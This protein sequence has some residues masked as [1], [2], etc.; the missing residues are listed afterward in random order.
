MPLILIAI[1]M[2]FLCSCGDTIVEGN[3]YTQ[4]NISGNISVIVLDAVTI[5]SVKNANVMLLGKDN[6]PMETNSNSTITYENLPVGN[7]YTFHIEAPGYASVLCKASVS[8][9][10]MAGS[11]ETVV[12]DDAVL[13]VYLPK[14]GA[15]LQGS[16]AYTDLQANTISIPAAG[17]GEAKLRLKLNIINEC[18]LINPYREASTGLNGTYFFDSLPELAHYELT[19]LESRIDNMVYRQFI[20]ESYGVLGLSGDIAKAP[21]GI[22]AEAVSLEKFR[23]LNAPDTVS[24]DGKISLLFSK[25]INKARTN[26]SA[27]Y[28][29]G[30]NYAVEAKWNGERTLEVSPIGG[31]WNV[32]DLITISNSSYLYATDGTY[33]NYG[34]L[35]AVRVTNGALGTVPKFWLEN[36]G[37]GTALNAK[38]DSL[39]LDTFNLQGQGLGFRWNK[40]NNA[41]S[42][43]IYAKCTGEINYTPLSVS[44]QS[45]TSAICSYS[46]AFYCFEKDRHSSFFIQA[47]N[48]RESTN[49][50]F[51]SVTGYVKETEQ[52]E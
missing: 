11:K 8:P 20:V 31:I 35:A 3:A 24:P 44:L 45:D 27:F 34:T 22:Y 33:L 29:T 9:D 1:F 48:P 7:N 38:G 21:L 40:A 49:S 47:K 46:S 43:V 28:I 50:D 23:L 12:V 19:A 2:L 17:N 41:A 32:N 4:G 5:L 6:K 16:I 25:D 10:S 51:I 13:K 15:K 52:G 14:L 18:E 37:T 39:D 30:M 26:I 42:Y 36:Y